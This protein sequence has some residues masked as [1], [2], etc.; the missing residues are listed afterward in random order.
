MLREALS[1]S[2]S[3]GYND[4]IWTY[5]LP[6]WYGASDKINGRNLDGTSRRPY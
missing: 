1:L 5:A 2:Y 3:K 4:G 6:R